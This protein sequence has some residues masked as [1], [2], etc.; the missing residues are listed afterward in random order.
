MQPTI[1]FFDPVTKQRYRTSDWHI[2]VKR[3]KGG[4]VTF[5]AVA[6]MPTTRT[7]WRVMPKSWAEK[8]IR[9]E[10]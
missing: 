9:T 5:Y 1:D 2:E 4:T 3:G 8:Y 10:T 6:E 7:V